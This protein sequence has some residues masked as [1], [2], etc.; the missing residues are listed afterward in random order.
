MAALHLSTSPAVKLSYSGLRTDTKS[1]PICF[2]QDEDSSE[3]ALLSCC[4][5]SQL[6]SLPAGAG[7]CVMPESLPALLRVYSGL[8]ARQCLWAFSVL[9]PVLATA[10]V[11]GESGVSRK[12]Q[13][14]QEKFRRWLFPKPFFFTTWKFHKMQQSHRSIPPTQ[15]NSE[16]V[17]N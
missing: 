7:S 15:F 10:S 6:I 4:R 5:G 12:A 3:V 9:R 16:L 8:G 2:H 1:R 13:P 14:Q 17:L 11:S